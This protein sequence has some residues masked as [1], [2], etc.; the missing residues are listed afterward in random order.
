[1]P[2]KGLLGL[3]SNKRSW[4]ARLAALVAV[5][6]VPGAALAAERPSASFDFKPANPRSGEQIKLTSS[7]CDPDGSLQS[8]DWDLDGDGL[9]DDATGPDAAVTLL[10]AGSH[11]VGL[12]VT[13]ADGAVSTRVRNV[14]VDSTYAIPRPDT[15]R[16]MSP[17]PVVT[18]GGRL[19]K[20]GVRVKLFSIRAPVCASVVVRCKGRGCP[21]R[22]TS[23]LVGRRALRLRALERRFRAGAKLT[24]AVSKGAQIGKFTTFKVRRGKA[25]LRS[26]RCLMPG[27]STGSRC[28]RD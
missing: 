4:A 27:A 7:S 19:T 12:R 10:G 1:V 11:S 20:A 23:A 17:F 21:R 28:P 2:R 8:Q 9:F 18:L 22:R 25:P 26:D 14:L 3:D 15:A 6:A 16:L 13:S 24:V 5:A